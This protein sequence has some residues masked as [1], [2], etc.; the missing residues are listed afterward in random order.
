M[1]HTLPISC[2]IQ[3]NNNN[4]NKSKRTL[5]KSI[6]ANF[7]L[8]L[9]S[10]LEILRKNAKNVS[11]YRWP[12]TGFKAG[13]VRIKTEILLLHPNWSVSCITYHF[14]PLNWLLQLC[15][16]QPRACC[17][18]P[19]GIERHPEV[20]DPSVLRSYVY[21]AFEFVLAACRISRRVNCTTH[22]ATSKYSRTSNNGHCRGIQILSVIGGVR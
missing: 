7:T 20:Q 13:T 4:N 19:V 6:V 22:H 10:F 2:L 9:S 15:S 18:L 14:L 3:N 21:T 12:R 5:E 17:L 1:L 11:G 8:S 16:H